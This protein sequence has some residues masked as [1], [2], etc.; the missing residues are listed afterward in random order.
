MLNNVN[1]LFPVCCKNSPEPCGHVTL[2]IYIICPW[3]I[4]RN[5]IVF[6]L[7]YIMSLL[8]LNWMNEPY[9]SNYHSRSIISF[10][11]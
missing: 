3:S 10:T 4:P 11:L 5:I 1:A 6:F 9:S 2:I 7:Q 8:Y